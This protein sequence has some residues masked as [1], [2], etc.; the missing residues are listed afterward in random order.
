M[1]FENFNKWTQDIYCQ[2]KIIK[3]KDVIN[4]HK[5][6]VDVLTQVVNEQNILLND[7]E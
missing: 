1:R 3:E 5:K 4:F 6:Y 7:I 2:S